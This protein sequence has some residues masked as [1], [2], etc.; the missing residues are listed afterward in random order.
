MAMRSTGLAVFA[1]LAGG[2][3]SLILNAGADDGGDDGMSSDRLPCLNATFGAAA[4]TLVYEDTGQLELTGSMISPTLPADQS[5]IYFSHDEPQSS[6]RDVWVATRVDTAALETVT[7]VDAHVVSELSDPLVDESNVQVSRDGTVIR[8]A[9]GDTTKM[10]F[11]SR[12]EGGVWTTPVPITEIF[13]KP[14][15]Y[16]PR[17]LEDPKLEVFAAQDGSVTRLEALDAQQNA[18]LVAMPE[19]ESRRTPWV[20]RDGRVMFYAARPGTTDDIAWVS[21]SGVDQPWGQEHL[22]AEL[23]TAMDERGAWLTDDLC[24][25]YF[26]RRSSPSSGDSHIFVARRAP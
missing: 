12:L 23:V 18:F 7:F 4:E 17:L 11:E 14:E 10:I 24:T 13:A 3:C 6:P 26:A 22:V 9:R 15:L 1:I 16:P 20:A 21:R 19:A 5:V 25:I 2:G 8:F